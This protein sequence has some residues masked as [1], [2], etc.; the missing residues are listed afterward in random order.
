[1]FQEGTERGYTPL[2]LA[3]MHGH[4]STV[5][6][7]I[8]HHGLDVKKQDRDNKAPVEYA[9]F[10]NHHEIVDFLQKVLLVSSLPL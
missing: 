8:E 7:L 10:F 4:I 6:Y 3:S 5:K 1:M 9:L 2:H